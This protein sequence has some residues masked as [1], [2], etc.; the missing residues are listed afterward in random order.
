MGLLATTEPTNSVRSASWHTE[1]PQL[2]HLG[3]HKKR[4]GIPT[5]T[6][7]VCQFLWQQN[8]ASFYDN[9]MADLQDMWTQVFYGLAVQS[10]PE[11]RREVPVVIWHLREALIQLTFSIFESKVRMAQEK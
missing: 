11:E 9:K 6:S 7:N 1:L 5:Q 2:P 3:L 8:G 10:R 4:R